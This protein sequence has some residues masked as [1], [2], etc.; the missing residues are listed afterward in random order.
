MYICSVFSPE[1]WR[2]TE[3]WNKKEKQSHR[4]FSAHFCEI[5]KQKLIL[6]EPNIKIVSSCIEL[7]YY[8]FFIL[9]TIQI[10]VLKWEK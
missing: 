1:I 2:Q 7:E 9:E 6:Y 3:N 4:F 10:L 8:P 5:Q